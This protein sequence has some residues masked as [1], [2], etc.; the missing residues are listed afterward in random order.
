MKKYDLYGE[1]IIENDSTLK[2]FAISLFKNVPFYFPV[3][4]DEDEDDIKDKMMAT[5]LSIIND[6]ISRTEIN[7][8]ELLCKFRFDIGDLLYEID[9][10]C[11][12][13]PEVA[14]FGDE[15]I[16]YFNI[17]IYLYINIHFDELK[18][19]MVEIEN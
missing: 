10:E 8:Q 14:Y 2:D 19:L 12:E 3:Y 1:N 16:E 7:Y 4:D 6:D 11:F 15:A 9:N 13:I 5:V 17:L 18:N